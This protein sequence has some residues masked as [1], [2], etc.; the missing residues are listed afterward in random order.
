MFGNF[1]KTFL[2]LFPDFVD[3]YNSLFDEPDRKKSCE[4]NQ[5]TSEM[6]IFALIRLG[7][8]DSERIARFLGYSVHTVN[9]Y[10]TRAKNRSRIPNEEFEP[11]VMSF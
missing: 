8:K 2:A 11:K 1:D 7:I 5:L 10:K 4:A 9:T 3:K 6:R